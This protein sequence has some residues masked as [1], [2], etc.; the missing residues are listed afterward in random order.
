MKKALDQ[1][2]LH[3]RLNLITFLIALAVGVAIFLV[4][5]FTRGQTIIAAI[6]GLAL[7]GMVVLVSGLLYWFSY[8]GAFDFVAFGFKQFGAMLFSKD[9]RKAGYFYDYQEDKRQKRLNS[10]YNFFA[11]MAAGLL[12]L[13]ALLVLEIVYK[14]NF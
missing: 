2:K 4:F 11:I 13:L 6:D 14:I 5:F 10:S 3:W 8:L 12:I 7:G 9:P 1:I